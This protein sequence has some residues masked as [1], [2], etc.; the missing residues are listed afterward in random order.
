[1]KV[2]RVWNHMKDREQIS[3][4]CTCLNALSARMT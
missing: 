1:V 4:A 2:E 3:T